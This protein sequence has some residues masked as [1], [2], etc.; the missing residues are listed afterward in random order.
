MR[1]F[2][3]NIKA[4]AILFLCVFSALSNQACEKER[5][6]FSEDPVVKIYPEIKRQII[7]SVGGNY[8]Q[9]NYTGKAWDLV[10]ETTLQ[11]FK[12]SHVRVAL[13][14]QFVNLQYEAYKGGK[15]LGQPAVESLLRAMKLM[16]EEYGVTNFT[17]SVWRVADEL[18]E[19]PE[20]QNKRRIKPD[21]YMAVIDMIE[22]FLVKAKDTY[23][24]EADYFSFNESNGGYMTIFSP[25]ET[26]RFVKMAGERF[27]EAG[28]KTRFLWGDTSSTKTTVDFA[29]K[30][31]ADSSIL[32]YLGPLSFHSWWS[33]DI[34]DTEFER[35]A[36]LA[37]KSGQPVWCTELG[38]DAMAHRTKGIFETWD[39]ALRFAQISHRVF[40]YA[41]AEVSMFWTWQKNYEIMSADA[42][43]KYP[44][45]YITRQQTDFLNNL[46]VV[47]SQSSDSDILP[48]CG[49]DKDNRLIVQLVN[50]KKKP[51]S[52]RLENI[53]GRKAKLVTTT[54][55]ELWKEKKV[56]LKPWQDAGVINLEAES[57]NT[58]IF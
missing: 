27:G 2:F 54:Q 22:A 38:F 12:P 57:V 42:K 10:G 21:K 15:I 11:E 51:V 41:K 50:V 1:S 45:Y 16:K 24:V 58:L 52:V 23:G 5:A 20:N 6:D 36:G 4:K 49:Y 9:A 39:Y 18:V 17:V 26:I 32:K 25:E 40:R 33:A 29:S 7:T 31:A 53:T 13:P 47:G 14:L 55:D 28:L 35:I 44:I 19:N 43:I 37:E 8:C 3:V 56:S 48:L 30:I 46:Q 34:P